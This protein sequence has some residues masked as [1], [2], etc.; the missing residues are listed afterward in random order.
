MIDNAV[1]SFISVRG[2]VTNTFPLENLPSKWVTKDVLPW[3]RFD[4]VAFA[5]DLLQLP[6]VGMQAPVS[7]V[8]LDYMVPLYDANFR[9]FLDKHCP[10]CTVQVKCGHDSTVTVG[11]HGGARCCRKRNITNRW[12]V[13]TETHGQQ[14]C[15]QGVVSNERRKKITETER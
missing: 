4:E 2:V 1:G 5:V 6:V 11:Y 8:D 7:D 14:R 13:A 3:K 10:A 15:V 9:K 12:T